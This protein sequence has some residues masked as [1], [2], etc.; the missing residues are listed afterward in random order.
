VSVE[1]HAARAWSMRCEIEHHAQ[2]RFARLSQD[3]MRLDAASPLVAL[4][5]DAS[6]EEARHARLCGE[7][8]Q[9]LGATPTVAPAVT[10]RVAPA[11][12]SPRDA[13]LYELVAACCVAETESM[14]TL[15]LLLSKMTPG[16]FR[17]AVHTITR[18]E[19]QHAQAGWA[20]LAREAVRRDLSWL[21]VHLVPMLDVPAVHEIFAPPPDAQADSEEL[22]Q[23]GVVPHSMK[24]VLLMSAIDQL[25]L[26]GLSQSG[27]DAAPLRA[28]LMKRPS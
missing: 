20:H 25:V 12:L 13:L 1:L 4:L 15:T 5:G 23:F 17:D 11:E 22:F 18:D 14:A 7:L 16:R 2:R 3:V 10:P 21:S 27:I 6:Q 24:R 9:H 26:P 28:W 19:V 8:A